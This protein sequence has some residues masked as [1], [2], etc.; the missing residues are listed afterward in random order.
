M[1]HIANNDLCMQRSDVPKIRDLQST[2]NETIY[3]EKIMEL[4]NKGILVLLGKTPRITQAMIS[5]LV[6]SIDSVKKAHNKPFFHGRHIVRDAP[7][8]ARAMEDPKSVLVNP[9]WQVQL[10]ILCIFECFGKT[11]SMFSVGL[12]RRLKG[13]PTLHLAATITALGVQLAPLRALGVI[14]PHLP[15]LVALEDLQLQVLGLQALLLR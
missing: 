5:L 7:E 10:E 12:L 6:T 14:A 8:W 11:W 2:D 3:Y 15:V 4:R 13:L 9:G 1:I